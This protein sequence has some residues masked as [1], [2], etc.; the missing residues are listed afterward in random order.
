VNLVGLSNLHALAVL[1]VV[2]S[3][4]LGVLGIIVVATESITD[5][6]F[7]KVAVGPVRT[8]LVSMRTIS[9][10]VELSSRIVLRS[11]MPVHVNGAHAALE[12][13]LGVWNNVSHVEVSNISLGYVGSGL[14]NSKIDAGLVIELKLRASAGIGIEICVEARFHLHIQKGHISTTR[15]GSNIRLDSDFGSWSG[16]RLCHGWSGIVA[17]AIPVHGE[18]DGRDGQCTSSDGETTDQTLE[19]GGL[20]LLVIGVGAFS[21]RAHG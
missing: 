16:S 9:A 13:L 12:V 21:R 8:R 14:R 17:S 10:L 4:E 5:F 18:D 20:V 7:G 1:P 2:G 6:S 11:Q 3:G 15:S 19:G